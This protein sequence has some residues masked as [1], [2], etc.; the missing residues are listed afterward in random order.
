MK[1]NV[2]VLGLINDREEILLVRTRKYPDYWQ[3]I[4]G[5]I[6]EEDTDAR[7]AIVR[8]VYEEAGL[9]IDPKI[10]SEVVQ[11]PFDFGEGT[12]FFFTAPCFDDQ[13]INIDEGEIVEAG[14]FAIQETEDIPVYPATKTFLGILREGIKR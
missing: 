6:D 5:G 11:T 1:R 9:R 14:W 7:A 8:E 4:G 13:K 2:A 10:M 12:V 3:P